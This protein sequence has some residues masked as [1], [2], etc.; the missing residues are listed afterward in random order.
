MASAPNF[1]GNRLHGQAVTAKMKELEIPLYTNTKAL[2]ITDSGVI[3]T[4][5]KYTADTVIYAVG[6]RALY[7][8]VDEL[9]F[10]A[11]EF[12]SVGDCNL[13]ANIT[14]A[15]KEAFYAARNIGRL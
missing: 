10:C 5:G 9:R 6:Q 8:E 2:E 12:Y 14:K 15:T 13:P 4:S 7:S 3:T 11:A 1:E